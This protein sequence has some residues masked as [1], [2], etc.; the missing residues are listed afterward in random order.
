MVKLNIEKLAE[1]FKEAEKARME[2]FNKAEE[3]RMKNFIKEIKFKEEQEEK[4]KI[5]SKQRLILEN[6]DVSKLNKNKANKIVKKKLVKNEKKVDKLKKKVRNLKKMKKSEI[7]RKYKNQKKYDKILF[8]AIKEEKVSYDYSKNLSDFMRTRSACVK[9][10][11]LASI[12]RGILTQ[13]PPYP[14]NKRRPIDKMTIGEVMEST[15]LRYFDSFWQDF[16]RMG[17]LNLKNTRKITAMNAQLLYHSFSMNVGN[18]SEMSKRFISKSINVTDEPSFALEIKDFELGGYGDSNYGIIIVGYVLLF[19]TKT[20][21]K[22]GRRVKMKMTP[23]DIQNLMAF[24]PPK[25]NNYKFN[26]FT[27]SSTSTK[28]KLCIYESF[29]DIIGE[30]SL[31]GIHK[32]SKKQVLSV[33]SLLKEEGIEIEEAVKSGLLINS[34]VLLTKKYDAEILIIFYESLMWTTRVGKEDN[35]FMDSEKD[36]PILIKKGEIK[37]LTVD[38]SLAE[39]V[40]TKVMVYSKKKH[41]APG[42]FKYK[43]FSKLD[44]EILDEYKKKLESRSF[45]LDPPKK[46]SKPF[47]NVVVEK[48]GKNFILTGGK[49]I[50]ILSFD[51]ETWTDENDIAQ[52]YCICLYGE[53]YETEENISQKQIRKSFY[54]KDSIDQFYGYINQ[55]SIISK[56]TNSNKKVCTPQIYI[57]GFN[58]SNFDNLLIY[59]KFH[60]NETP[61]NFLITQNSIKKIQYNNVHFFDLRLFY[62][63]GDLKSTYK[64]FFPKSE[65]SKGPFPYDF[66]NSKNLNYIGDIPEVKYWTSKEQ[67]D[68]Y[69]EETSDTIFDMKDYTKKYCMLDCRLTHRIALAHFES[70]S[71]LINERN[72]SVMG[73]PTGAGL[74]LSIFKQ[75]FLGESL[76]QSPKWLLTA[77]RDSYKG[78]RTEAFKK[79][80]SSENGEKLYYYDINS[81]YPYSM[82]KQMPRKYS[83]TLKLDGMLAKIEKIVPYNLYQVTSEYKG[84]NKNMI[85]NLLIRD[86]RGNNVSLLNIDKSWHWGCEIIEAIESEFEVKLYLEHVY[87]GGEIFRPFIEYFYNERLK[88]KKTNTALANFYKLIINSLYG[89][90]GQRN[91]NENGI[92]DSM[93]EIYKKLNYNSNLLLDV[94]DLGDKIK[95][96]YE[97]SRTKKEGIGSMVRFSSYIAAESRTNL[98]KM[99]RLVGYENVYYCDTDSVFINKLP[100]AEL[101]SDSILGKWKDELEGHKFI[102]EAY[103]IA[104]K[105]YTLIYE[106]KFDDEGNKIDL[107]STKKAKG[108]KGDK[109][110]EENYKKLIIENYNI[111]CKIEYLKT[112]EKYDILFE[113]TRDYKKEIKELENSSKGY[114]Q[115]DTLLFFKSFNGVTIKNGQIRTLKC[116]YNKRKWDLTNDIFSFIET[117]NIIGNVSYPFKDIEEF[118]KEYN[119]KTKENNSIN[120]DILELCINE[121]LIRKK[122]EKLRRAKTREFIVYP[123]GIVY[124]SGKDKTINNFVMFNNVVMLD[125]IESQNKNSNAGL[126]TCKGLDK[127]LVNNEEKLEKYKYVDPEYR[128]MRDI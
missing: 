5:D 12:N 90:F 85:P 46:K 61:N 45:S 96:E 18:E 77:E 104:P 50:Y 115:D 8:N 86:E 81:S 13:M 67:R 91:F 26:K 106:D 56:E 69:L 119:L 22:D 37:E 73:C 48:K 121:D 125:Y 75:C 38:D 116:V 11:N 82:T 118:N 117:G 71:G 98:A 76:Y 52:C 128:L 68:T 105:V 58:N 66:V 92:A 80:F 127:L 59:K 97:S 63:L 35:F 10:R 19:G 53:I 2:A 40:G 16:L 100:P 103:F 21:E 72:Y 9:S 15:T 43:W 79:Y 30:R 102:K 29:L 123:N 112:L 4:R 60:D 122:S 88:V 87:E 101:L 36:M 57:Y 31:R 33:N 23:R 95:Y 6:K 54:G 62:S 20:E 93:D 107:K 42:L 55:I 34:L 17:K 110:S 14:Y 74:S 41:V 32:D 114:E 1:E 44:K 64:A 108:M 83:I 27:T 120:S 65:L 84:T 111:N 25:A 78:G 24:A 124:Y 3:K 94:V 28:T 49:K 70:C 99:M 126:Y 89:K 7:K 39:Y 47:Y 109:I 113:D 51:A